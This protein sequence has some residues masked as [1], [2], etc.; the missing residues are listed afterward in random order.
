MVIKVSEDIILESWQTS[1]ID[2]LLENANSKN[3]A[4]FMMDSFPHPYTKNNAISWV[5]YN[6]E[7]P[8]GINFAIVYQGQCVGAIGGLKK[9]DIYKNTL[10]IGYWIGEKFQRK[11]IVSKSLSKYISYIFKHKTINRIEAR[12]FRKN[13]ASYSLLNKLGFT[14][15]A[16]MKEAAIKFGNSIDIYLFRLLKS[17][18]DD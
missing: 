6:M 3:I 10:E 1:H 7:N 18:F 13:L 15:E 5:N 17:E 2:S 16:L 11:S 4:Q 14:K 8:D 12:V 9:F